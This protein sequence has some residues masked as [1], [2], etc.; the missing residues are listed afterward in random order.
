[1]MK[2]KDQMKR[3]LMILVIIII[4]TTTTTLAIASS[5]IPIPNSVWTTSITQPQ[6]RST[7]RLVV[8]DGSGF[9]ACYIAANSTL[10]CPLSYNDMLPTKSNNLVFKLP[11]TTNYQ[12][13]SGYAAVVCG[14]SHQGAATCWST[15][16]F[17]VAQPP[18]QTFSSITYGQS[19]GCGILA[20]SGVAACWGI[21]LAQ[22]A[23]GSLLPSV[24]IPKTIRWR[25]LSWGYGSCCGLTFDTNQLQCFGAAA[26][27]LPWQ[28]YSSITDWTTWQMALASGCGL[29]S[30]GTLICI[31]YPYPYYY[32]LD[33]SPEWAYNNTNSPVDKLFTTIWVTPYIACGALLHEDRLICWG[34][35][36]LALLPFFFFLLHSKQCR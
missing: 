19:A 1:M 18:Y 29:R 7:L 32:Y 16:G 27:L 15:E 4:T 22:V 28:Q 34:N 3:L 23:D 9:A 17:Y 35:A 8:G 24:S 13:I 20:S 6:P 11:A 36:T 25:S 10:Q 5:D 2:R 31:S 21:E 26:T 12:S 14:L 30:N 33:E